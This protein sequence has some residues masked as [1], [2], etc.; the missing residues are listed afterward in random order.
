MGLFKPVMPNSLMAKEKGTFLGRSPRAIR[1][2]RQLQ[3][4]HAQ[5]R[6]ALQHT[7]N[8]PAY[9]RG[10]RA[11]VQLLAERTH[12]RCGQI[13]RDENPEVQLVEQ[14]MTGH[15]ASKLGQDA[16]GSVSP[17]NEGQVDRWRAG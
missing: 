7:T 6:I 9:R 15:K 17:M 3:P 12:N 5:R 13:A 10:K 8:G 4:D 1:S 11:R 14:D 16:A 2:T